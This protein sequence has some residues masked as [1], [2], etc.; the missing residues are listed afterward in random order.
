ML[1]LTLGLELLYTKTTVA[2]SASYVSKDLEWTLTLNFRVT[3]KIDRNAVSG[4]RTST[5]VY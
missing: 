3:F 2:D 5:I 4:S 1:I